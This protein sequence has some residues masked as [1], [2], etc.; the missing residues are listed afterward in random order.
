MSPERFE[1]LLSLVGPLIAKKKCR[2]REPLSPAERLVITL[3]YLASGDS[4]QSQS[5]NFRA[6]RSTICHI[7]RDT[8][9]GIWNAL[10]GKY[11]CAPETSS[12]W[13]KIAAR[14]EED[15]NFPNCIG[16]LDG[17]HIA[18]ECPSNAGS[19][20]Y[21]YKGFHS[22]VLMA[23]CDANYCFSLVDIGNF[24][25]DNDAAIF[26][27]S[28]MGMAFHEGEMNLPTAEV[29]DG[30]CLPFVIVS[31]EIF[32]LKEWLMKPYPGRNLG[33]EEEI[34]NYRL[35]RC[36]RTIENTFG[37]LAAKWRIF[38]RPIRA[39]VETAE[40]VT[41]ACICLHNYLKQTENACYVPAGFVDTE[42]DSGTIVPGSWRSE[43]AD[44]VSA[45]QTVNRVGSNNYRKD[46]KETR[47]QFKLYFNSP[48]GSLPWQAKHVQSCGEKLSAV[49]CG[50]EK[51]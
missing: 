44:D 12:D 9:D 48:S 17:K 41:K 43:V 11:L 39:K 7:I 24:G 38:R 18:I 29:I 3:R 34:F 10:N 33:E 47:N 1:N 13:K 20:Y 25:R 5:F 28:N 16:A 50:Q 42:D 15:W 26:N 51:N 8:C 35:S 2:S 32:P 30:F 6:G 31:D 46:A 19:M 21:N 14:F 49:N 37:I 36:R 45:L 40:R 4:Q 22:L 27:Q 23:M